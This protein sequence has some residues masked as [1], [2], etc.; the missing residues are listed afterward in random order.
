MGWVNFVTNFGRHFSRWWRPC[1]FFCN[2]KY[3]FGFY[4]LFSLEIHK[5]HVGIRP[6]FIFASI[7]DAILNCAKCSTLTEWHQTDLESTGRHLSE[8][9]KKPSS[10]SKSTST[11]LASRLQVI[12]V[13]SFTL[14]P[15]SYGY[16]F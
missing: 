14:V 16:C 1:Y 3:K 6:F 9:V 8:S 15:H 4:R 12:H 10:Y 7:L 5:S 13:Y 11:S 2:F